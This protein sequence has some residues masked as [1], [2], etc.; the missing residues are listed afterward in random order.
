MDA[1]EPDPSLLLT[2]GEAQP[3]DVGRGLARLLPGDLAALGLQPGD[4]I[5]VGGSRSTV[6]RVVPIFEA[7]CPP[8]TIQID[9]IIRANAQVAIGDQVRVQ[10]AAAEPAATAVF[11]PAT[12]TDAFTREDAARYLGRALNGLVVTRGDRVRVNLFG[13]RYQEFTVADTSPGGAVV[14]GAVTRVSVRSSAAPSRDP[15][16]VTYE[17]IGA[18]RREIHRIREM[19]EL[20]LRHPELFERLGIE[21]PRGVLLYGPPGTGKTLIAR[22]VANETDAAFFYLGG[23][24]VIHKFY[25][26]SEANLRAI[27][28]QASA[29]AP[30]I[31]FIDEIDA[32]AAKREEVR[33]DQQVERR[34]VAQLLSLMDGLRSRGQVIVIGATNL[35]Q[36]LDPALRRPGRFDREIGIGVP[37]RAGRLE[38]L[39]IHSRGMP[40][41]EDVSLERLA[42]ITHGFVGADLEALCREAAMVTLREIMPRLQRDR[43]GLAYEELANLRVRMDHFLT[44]LGEIEPSA[45]REIFTERPEVSWDEVGGLERAKRALVEAVEWPLRYPRLFQRADAAPPR[46]ILLTGPPGSGKTLLARAVARRCEVSFISV[47]GSSV[48]SRWVGETEQRLSEVFKKAR[49]ASP[50]L[51]FLDEL[52][53]LAPVRAASDPAA[54]RLVA[55]LLTE[56]DGIEDRAGLIVLAATNR[57]ELVDPALLRAGRFD[58]RLELPL[59]DEQARIDIL[60]V[61]IRG[62]LLADDVNLAGLA[63]R[64]AGWSGA[65]LAALCRAAALAAIREQVESDP[66]QEQDASARLSLTAQHFEQGLAEI[67]HSRPAGQPAFD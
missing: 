40:L 60:A 28:E 3:R 7:D 42:E 53:A 25:G 49:Q 32:I 27:F 14:L 59:P 44:A 35:P 37:D 65:D 10:P 18:L 33:G 15:G 13:S 56:L 9:G 1:R 66:L 23:P 41:A 55:A 24:E 57:P 8:G 64:T 52:D 21:A 11:S 61:H 43:D 51:L 36:V 17:D 16:G 45:I 26:E 50:C 31:V 63:R 39:Q 62:K 22:A 58:L 54:E 19:V 4:V 67:W 20:P 48:L 2:I 30:S 29:E 12:P 6:A 34:V 47:K 5:A 38:I 46:G